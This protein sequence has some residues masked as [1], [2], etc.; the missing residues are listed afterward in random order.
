[1]EVPPF[2]SAGSS[3][4]AFG[5]LETRRRCRL[6]QWDGDRVEGI[7]GRDHR[8]GS[9]SAEKARITIGADGRNS[10]LAR[11]VGDSSY[12]ETPTLTCWYFSYWSGVPAEGF[13][14]YVRSNRAIFSFLTN[15]NLFAIFIGWPVNNFYSVKADIEG[16]FIR[17]VDLVPEFAERVRC[18]RHEERFYG[19]ADLP[20]FLR[21][22]F[23]PGWAL[24]G[25]AGCHKDPLMGTGIYDALRDADLLAA[26]VHESLAG[27]SSFNDALMRYERRRKEAAMAEYCENIAAARFPP[28]PPELLRLRMALR[29]K[30]EDT[31]RFIMAREGMIP[32]EE[33]FNPEN[34]Q[35]IESEFE[36]AVTVRVSQK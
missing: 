16:Q 24:V 14:W 28:T 11:A 27:E 10:D 23:G 29:D 35:R 4:Q 19:T 8:Q 2:T 9:S 25:D 33:F 13:E 26:A 1:V 36:A 32:P 21:R 6:C 15:D 3:N 20:N 34:L 12:E 18:G 30:Q 5:K 17:V 7:R 22:P 31:K